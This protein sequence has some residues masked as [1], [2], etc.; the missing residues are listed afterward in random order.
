M[1]LKKA[2]LVSVVAHTSTT[3]YSKILNILQKKKD[4]GQRK[5]IPR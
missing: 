1:Q 2:E 5:N 4:S 3:E